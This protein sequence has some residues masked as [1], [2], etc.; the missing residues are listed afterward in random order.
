[1]PQFN[2]DNQKE[3]KIDIDKIKTKIEL[4]LYSA[5]NIEGTFTAHELHR[6]QQ[7]LGIQPAKG[8]QAPEVGAVLGHH[9]FL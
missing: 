5:A 1:M 9:R 7:P 3:L 8:W 6:Q 4:V 2:K